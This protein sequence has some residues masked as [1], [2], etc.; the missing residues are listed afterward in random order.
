MTVVTPA[1]GLVIN[2]EEQ[3]FVNDNQ[4]IIAL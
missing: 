1:C 2:P 3:I 4:S